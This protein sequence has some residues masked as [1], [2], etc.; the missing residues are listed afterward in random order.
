MKMGLFMTQAPYLIEVL[1]KRYFTFDLIMIIGARKLS[2][3]QQELKRQQA[4]TFRKKGKSSKR[5]TRCS[6][7]TLIPL[8][9]DISVIKRAVKK[10]IFKNE[11]QK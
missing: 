10:L 4:V 6:M 2:T 5:L 8:V 9:A 1:A 3:E 11:G 7:S